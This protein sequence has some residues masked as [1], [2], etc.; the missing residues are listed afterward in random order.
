MKAPYKSNWIHY[1]HFTNKGTKKYGG[2]RTPQGQT[3]AEL[4]IAF[5]YWGVKGS[6]H[7][8][9]MHPHGPQFPI[10][11]LWG[12][13]FPCPPPHQGDNRELGPRFLKACVCCVSL[14]STARNASSWAHPA[15]PPTHAKLRSMSVKPLSPPSQSLRS[16]L[17]TDV[18]RAAMGSWAPS[19]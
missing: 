4:R 2:Q 8:Y 5:M 6:H 10:I 12:V 16:T 11:S 17:V 15:R 1:S 9:C 18:S 3:V 14:P 7:F 19:L 13:M